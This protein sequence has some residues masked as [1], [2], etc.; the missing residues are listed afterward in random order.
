MTRTGFPQQVDAS[1]RVNAVN[2]M[3]GGNPWF[4]DVL[5]K[6][7]TSG[8]QTGVVTIST[9]TT[10]G[11]RAE[12]AERAVRY[13]ADRF[14]AA[15]IAAPVDNHTGEWRAIVDLPDDVVR[16]VLIGAGLDTTITV[17]IPGKAWDRLTDWRDDRP[18]YATLMQALDNATER[19]WGS[20]TRVTVTV[21]REDA[22]LL[23]TECQERGDY[24]IDTADG[25]RGYDSYTA[26]DLRAV[27]RAL[28]KTGQQ[29]RQQLA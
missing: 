9:V 12:Y 8:V 17:M 6:V 16:T 15:G 19:R 21:T 14:R 26:R 2:A 25:W 7:W 24:E 11:G 27:G 23:A 4:I 3:I 28:I 18:V 10:A 22:Q 29:I 5:F 20:G 1:D 13:A